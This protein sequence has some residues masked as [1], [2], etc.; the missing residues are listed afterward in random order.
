MFFIPFVR[1]WVLRILSN[2]WYSS[3]MT[4]YI[5]T[6]KMTWSSWTSPRPTQHTDTPYRSSISL[7]RRSGASRVA[8]RC[9]CPA[10]GQPLKDLWKVIHHRVPLFLEGFLEQYFDRISYP[11]SFFSSPMGGHCVFLGWSCKGSTRLIPNS[12]YLDLVGDMQRKL[13]NEQTDL[14]PLIRI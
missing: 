12:L 1:S 8:A 9:G 5:A 4:A 11:S 6:S 2:I 3:T 14:I 10:D 13:E 7:N